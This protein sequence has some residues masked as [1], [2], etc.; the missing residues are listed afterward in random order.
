MLQ[1]LLHSMSK[2]ASRRNLY[3]FI[4]SELMQIDDGACI[5]NVCAGGE[6][7]DLLNQICN[8]KKI[9][10]VS[11]DISPDRR[12]DVVADICMTEYSNE[13]D[14]IIL[15]EVLEHVQHPRVACRKIYD[16]LRPCGRLIMTTPFI[17]PIHDQPHDYWRFTRYGLE[18]LLREAGFSAPIIKERNGWGEAITVLLWRVVNTRGH[19]R[20]ARYLA[21]GMALMFFP[22]GRIMSL[23]S[24]HD[25]LTTGY[26][27]VATK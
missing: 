12:P 1:D 22:I 13:F 18:H 4:C 8:P 26:T 10:V 15:A 14:A 11:L 7:S 17:F 20:C 21:G 24:P 16:A 27:A 3:E 9:S 19:S 6:I 25:F 2:K 23:I 5:L